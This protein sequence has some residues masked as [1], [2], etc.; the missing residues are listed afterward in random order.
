MTD[1]SNALAA[2]QAAQDELHERRQAVLIAQQRVQR[3]TG[4]L[5]GALVGAYAHHIR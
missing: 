1:Y 3:L 2:L 4:E 5:I